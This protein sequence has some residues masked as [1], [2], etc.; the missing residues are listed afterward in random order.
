MKILFLLFHGFS[1]HSGISKKIR[2][3]IDGLKENG[4]DVKLCYYMVDED[5]SRKRIID[6][7]ILEDYGFSIKGKVKQRIFFGSIVNYI[8]NNNIEVVYMRSIHNANPFTI[9]FIHQLK[10]KGV[11]VV[12]EIPTYPYDNEYKEEPL[13]YKLELLIDKLF[14][15]SLVKQLERV[16]TFSN[17]Q[18]IFGGKT[19]NISN[20]VDFSLIKLKSNLNDTSK[21]LH[22]IGVAEVH[23][24]HGFD[25]LIKG[26]G[27]YYKKDRNYNVFFHLIGGLGPL[28]KSEYEQLVIENRLE[29]YVIFHDTKFG[30]ELDLLFE[31]SDMGIGSL[32]RHR[33]NITNIKTLKNREY[34][35]RGI[36][37]IYSEI[38]DDFEQMPYVLKA[39]AD[40]SP[41][42]IDNIIFFYRSCDIT[43]IKI[44]ES[45]T[46]LSWKEQMKKVIQTIS[47]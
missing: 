38:D 7:Y 9:Y 41:I 2:A 35:A 14:R 3:Q 21:E 40:E 20:G 22:L 39:T 4:H 17:E 23:Y 11:K 34:A 31:Q 5:G 15:H 13:K 33:S 16:V 43:P 26:L 47:L 18:S 30:A 8:T 28:E 42:N 36:P 46:H 27:E 12:M 44:R 25:R 29:K 1:E 19:I 6:D 24:W 10:K 45:I 32:A 37:F